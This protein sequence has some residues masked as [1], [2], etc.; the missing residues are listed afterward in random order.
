MDA[1]LPVVDIS[2]LN[3]YVLPHPTSL[4]ISSPTVPKAAPR[5]GSGSGGS[6]LGKDFR[7][8]YLP[9]VTLTGAGQMLGLLEFDGY[10]PNDISAYETTAGLPAVPLQ[11]V[12]LDGYDGAPTTGRRSGNDEVSLDIEVAVA[13]APGLAGIIVFEAG[14]GGLQNDILNAMAASNQVRQFS[15]SWAWGGGPS[16]TTDNIFKQMAIQGQSFFNAAGDSDAFTSGEVD[17]PSQGFAPASSPY[18]T[19]VGGT[20]LTTGSGGSWLS[21]SVWNQGGGVGGSGGIST[22]YPI[23][24]WQLGISMTANGGSTN[25]RNAFC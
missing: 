5:T 22:F 2:G 3:N 20:T 8:A 14:P 12:L 4:K 25:Q 21:E 1:E 17:D 18:I 13:M 19:Q 9:G 24:P 11:T 7:N 6:Y 10:Y 16:A 15:C 23:P